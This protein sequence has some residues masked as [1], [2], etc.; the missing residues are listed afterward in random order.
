[1][2]AALAAHDEVLRS[3]IEARGGW[4]FKHTGDG[5]CAA[6]ASARAAVDA[7]I[8]AQLVLDLPVRMGIATGEAERRGDDYF[9]PALNRA[10]RIMGAGHGGQILVAA[11]TT[12]LVTDVELLDLGERRLRD[13]SGALRLFQVCADGLRHDFPPLKTIDGVPGNLHVQ[14]TSFVG[15]EV[16][17]LTAAVKAHRLVTLTGV[18]GVGK[19]RLALQVAGELVPEF[20]DG[21]WLVELAPVGDPVAVPD[22]VATA[23][24]LTPQPG[25]SVTDSIAEGLAGRRLLVVF[26]NCEHVLDAV[27]DVVEAVLAR[28]NTAHALATSREGLR[29]PAEHLWP[30]PSLGVREGAESAA[31]ALFVERARAVVP[32]FSLNG[33]SDAVT[34]ICRRLDGIALAIEL[35]AA[36]MVSMSP[37]DVRDRLDDRFRLLAGGRRGP[38]RHQTLRHAVQWSYDLLANDE[39]GLL[40]GCSVF[41]RGFDLKAAVQ[42][43]GSDAL[44]EFSVLELL[45]SLVRKSLVVADQ[46]GGAARY[47]LLETI[48]KF[49]EDQLAASGTRDETRDRH[50]RHFA[51][52]ADVNFERWASPRQ[53]DA[54]VWVDAELANLRAGFRWSVERNDLDTAASIANKA[55]S[56]ATW[57]QS[58]EPIGWAEQLLDSARAQ[59]HRSLSQLYASATLC[60][61]LG[62][63][64]DAVRYSKAGLTMIDDPEYDEAPYGWDTVL[65]SLVYIF[66]GPFERVVEL[67]AACIE[68]SGDPFVISR[69]AAVWALAVMRRFDEAIAMAE[70]AVAAA[71]DTG[72]PLSIAYALDCYATAFAERDPMRALMARRRALVIAR[73]SDNRMIEAISARGLASLEAVH[74]DPR[75]GLESFDDTID[76]FHQSGAA[77][78]LVDTFAYLAEF[79]DRIERPS[80]AATLY[81]ASGRHALA[82]ALV[83]RLPVVADHLRGVLGS[84]AFDDLARKGAAMDRSQAVAYA[85]AEIQ[86][87]REELGEGGGVNVAS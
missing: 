50:A 14:A 24:G 21:V 4:M 57:I 73:D 48:R 3:A 71:E 86:R 36:R 85:H 87:A 68:R 58:H 79:F 76:W 40:N 15:R 45:D 18:G 46:S 82:M 44:D 42:V 23:L 84:A 55:A 54:Y 25:M 11:S 66:A 65:L 43:C 26:D 8:D 34:E 47:T 22:A 17:E 31:V 37:A 64:E 53:R 13:L 67:S 78:N 83:P 49:G 35:A 27:A 51:A 81:G 7:A 38:E 1:M 32:G 61:F 10:A 77:A 29:L 56:V 52:E 5:V 9:G 70:H 75:T 6:F 72:I 59:H 2:R 69:S 16:E 62:R 30:V 12:A 39:R 33:N 20:A 60:C 80:A 28:S 19:T 74:G 63:L 41:A